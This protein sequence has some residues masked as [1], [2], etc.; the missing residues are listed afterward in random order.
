M[1]GIDR[2][3]TV[4][5]AL[6]T[7]DL[8]HCPGLRPAERARLVRLQRRLARARRGSRRRDRVRLAIARLKA[9]EG[10]R[11]KDWAE[12]AS[13]ALARRFDLIRVEDLQDHQHDPLGPGHHRAARP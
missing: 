12:K 7:G 6:S 2:G 11:R 8:L 5:A 1:V 3:V 10:D 4:S 9:R 13:T